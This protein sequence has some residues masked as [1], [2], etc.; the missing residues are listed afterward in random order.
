VKVLIAAGDSNLRLALELLVD[1]E[2]AATVVGSAAEGDGLLALIQTARPRIV[3]A[4]WE[5]PGRPVADILR[6][7]AQSTQRPKF[8]ILG[9]IQEME[10][11]AIAAGADAF[12]DRTDP[13][14]SLLAAFRKLRKYRL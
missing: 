4:E 6:H 12:V 11:E 1:G 8:I 3:I 13:P 9:G 5:L 2:P 10:A 14:E 7:F